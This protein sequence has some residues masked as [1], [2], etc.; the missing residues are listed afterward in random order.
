MFLSVRIEE[1]CDGDYG[2]LLREILRVCQGI[3]WDEFEVNGAARRVV[4]DLAGIEVIANPSR[5]IGFKKAFDLHRFAT[6]ILNVI[7]NVEGFR[8]GHRVRIVREIDI[9]LVV[10]SGVDGTR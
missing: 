7:G 6:V 4:H 8:V 5:F 3:P 1:T 9:D 10:V 2:I